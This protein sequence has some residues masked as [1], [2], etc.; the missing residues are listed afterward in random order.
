M[1]YRLAFGACG[2]SLVVA[3][4][5]HV[6][7]VGSSSLV[8]ANGVRISSTSGVANNCGAPAIANSHSYT[9]KNTVID[10]GGRSERDPY[11]EF[12]DPG[13]DKNRAKQAVNILR[14]FDSEF[15]GACSDWV[16][17]PENEKAPFLAH[18]DA[19]LVGL[20][21]SATRLEAQTTNDGFV[22]EMELARKR[23][24]DLEARKPQGARW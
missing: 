21:E 8:T 6:P 14:R 5:V 7:P 18:H 19:A 22:A 13:I 4:G 9:I 23:I 3:C 20:I 24:D 12:A 16:R 15:R 10:V 11:F 1:R 17:V 2:I